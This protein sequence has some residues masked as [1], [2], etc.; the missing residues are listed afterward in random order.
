[1]GALDACSWVMNQCLWMPSVGCMHAIIYRHPPLAG[2]FW[3][4]AAT[5]DDPAR[6]AV[7]DALV[8][9]LHASAV[10]T[11][12]PP[13]L[14]LRYASAAPAWPRTRARA[15]APPTQTALSHTRSRRYASPQVLRL[16]EVPPPPPSTDGV[17]IVGGLSS[18]Q[19]SAEEL[20]A[21][22]SRCDAQQA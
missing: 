7:A 20:G 8:A 1:M 14:R 3:V 21:L 6:N 5:Y 12:V 16:P 10:G 4:H 9:D 13:P 2:L 11:T 18:H 15:H 17:V 19:P 22:L